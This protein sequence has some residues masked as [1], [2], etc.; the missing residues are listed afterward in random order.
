MQYAPTLCAINTKLL[1]LQYTKYKTHKNALICF[2]T[3]RR[4]TRKVNK[5]TCKRDP[6][7]KVNKVNKQKEHERKQRNIGLNDI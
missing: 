5:E 1:I 3:S 4:F 7:N 6:Q 2:D